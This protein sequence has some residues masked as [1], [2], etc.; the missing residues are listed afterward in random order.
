M[1]GSR[2]PSLRDGRF[3]SRFGTRT[4]APAAVD[5]A[6]REDGGVENAEA[7]LSP[8]AEAASLRDRVEAAITEN[9]ADLDFGVAEL[10]WRRPLVPPSCDVG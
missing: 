3:G 6:E 8:T 4:E 2:T 7:A 9:L 10:A 1:H 5:E